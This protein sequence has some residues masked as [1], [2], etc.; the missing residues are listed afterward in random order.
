[1]GGGWYR[2]QTTISTSIIR[3]VL[4]CGKLGLSL[5]CPHKGLNCFYLLFFL[6]CCMFVYLLL[7][8]VSSLGLK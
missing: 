7:L 3:T 1:M 4:W 5:W 2:Y 6:W 8:L